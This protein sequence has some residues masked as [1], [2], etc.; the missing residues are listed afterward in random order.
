MQHLTSKMKQDWFEYIIKRDGGFRCFY[1]KKTL[2]L[3][4][5]V[6]D[7]LNDNR[8]DNR[9]ENIVHA[10]YT[11]NNKKKFN[12]DMLLS[13][14]DKL[15]EN[16]IGNS[17]RERISL[18]PRELKELDIS[19]ENYEIAEDYITK[20]VDVNGYIKVKETKNSI[21]YLCR[22]A[23]GTGSP[24]AVSNYISTLTSTEA[25]FEIIKNEDG[26][27]IIQRKQP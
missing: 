4:N 15:N 6:H 10:C 7:H 23:N 12:F 22:T 24:Q 1:C 27:K 13:A 5:F 21:A 9:I 26:E 19:K 11:C 2:S 18:K 20:Q 8:K 17:M 25:P 3:T 14:K 16:E